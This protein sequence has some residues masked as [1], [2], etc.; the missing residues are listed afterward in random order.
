MLRV[1]TE[2]TGS[3][4]LLKY[5]VNDNLLGSAIDS[6]HTAGKLGA[7]TA[8]GQKATVTFADLFVFPLDSTRI[9]P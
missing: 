7:A 8:G 5:Y 3:G 1:V 2:D 6:D 9:G 4:H